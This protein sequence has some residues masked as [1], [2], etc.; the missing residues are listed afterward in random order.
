MQYARVDRTDGKIRDLLINRSAF[1]ALQSGYSIPD[2]TIL[3]V[4][5]YDA[6]RDAN[7]DIILDEQGRYIK[8]TPFESLHIA[9]KRSDWTDADFPSSARVGEWNFGSFTPD[10]KPFDENLT[11]CFNCHQVPINTDFLYT[12]RQLARFSSSGEIQ[13]FL[14]NLSDRIA[15]PEETAGF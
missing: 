2:D 1:D 8:D 6:R 9:N 14:C 11:A 3:V 4:S 5:G 12:Y 7:G 15:C 13:Y 10:G